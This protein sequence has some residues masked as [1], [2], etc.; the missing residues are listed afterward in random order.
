MM[1]PACGGG[2]VSEDCL[3][4][5][6]FEEQHWWEEGKVGTGRQGG[7]NGH[8]DMGNLRKPRRGPGVPAGGVIK[9]SWR[10]GWG[11]EGRQR[12]LSEPVSF[13]HDFR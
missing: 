7:R 11:V 5:R 2:G 3:P 13:V 12:P 9:R 4:G 8:G 1:A 6:R 10:S